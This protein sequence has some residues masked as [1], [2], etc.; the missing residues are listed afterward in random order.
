MLIKKSHLLSNTARQ[1]NS[2][3]E[4]YLQV[5]VICFVNA[6]AAAIYV[7]MQFFP[8]PEII[9]LM[10]QYGWLL[11]HGAP[12]IIYLSINKS[13]QRKI[14]KIINRGNNTVSVIKTS[15][16]VTQT[17]SAGIVSIT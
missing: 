17:S 2:Q 1:S 14:K 6:T 9:I 15:Q 13:I 12:S 7:Y 4:S 5:F 3:K 10:G 11:A 16:P 8:V